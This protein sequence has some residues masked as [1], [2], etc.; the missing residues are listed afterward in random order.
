MSDSWPEFFENFLR[1]R[2]SMNVS[3]RQI[4]SSLQTELRVQSMKMDGVKAFKLSD[5]GDMPDEQQGEV[6]P[7]FLPESKTWVEEGIL[8]THPQDKERPMKLFPLEK[9]TQIAIDLFDGETTIAEIARNLA[10]VMG[11][12]ISRSFAYTRGLFL[13]LVFAKVCGPRS[14]LI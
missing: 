6:Y 13:S 8:W 14:P 11:W 7:V 10:E 3:R 1:D 9:P 5:L 12:N 2:L 4:L